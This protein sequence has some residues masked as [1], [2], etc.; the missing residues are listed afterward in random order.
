MITAELDDALASDDPEE[1]R[2]AVARLGDLDREAC[3]PRLLAA[4][5][6]DDWRVR[7][8]AIGAAVALAPAP[9]VLRA[10]VEAIGTGQ[11]VGLRNAA[12]EAL[13]GFGA[14]AVDALSV[15]ISQLDADGR[16]LAVEALGRSRQVEALAVLRGLLEDPD[17][18]V[19]ATAVEAVAQIGASSL[20][21]AVPLLE[22]CL[23]SGDR[24]LELAALDG[25]NQLGVILPWHS[26]ADLL[27][28]PV[29]EPAALVAA[30]R[31][32]HPAAATRIVRCLSRASGRRWRSALVA[33]AEYVQLSER[34]LSAARA[35][36]GDVPL[37]A[38]EELLQAARRAGDDPDERRAALVACGALG[39]EEAASAAIE[40]LSDDLVAAEGERA[41]GLLGPQAIK[42]LLGVARTGQPAARARCIDLLGQLGDQLPS[43]AALAIAAALES[44]SQDVVRAALAALAAIGDES[45]LARV[46]RC[47]D[48]DGPATL[49]KAAM[50][51]LA[52]LARRHPFAAR[53]L[54]ARAGPDSADALAAATV[55]GA[56]ESPVL[57]GV[58]QDVSFLSAALS[59]ENA[60][61]R[62]AAVDGLA[63][64]GSAL[65]VEAV[66]FALTDE[67][68]EVALAAV[69]ALG[70][71]RNQDGSIAGI[72]HLLELVEHSEDEALVAAAV[73]AL[74]DTGDVRALSALR[75]LVKS[76]AAMAGV[77]AVEALGRLPGPQA[78]DALIDALGHS[79][80]EVVKSA[81]R[82]LA[83][84]GEP[85][86]LAHLGA[87]LDHEAW[88]VRRLSAD[89]LGQSGR[90]TA[91]GMLRAKLGTE[92][93]PLVREAIQRALSEIEMAIGTVR[94]TAPPPR[95]G[96]WPPRS[97]S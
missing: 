31:S 82:V 56:L 43:D 69:R 11:G 35:A 13:S 81:L 8:E 64:I 79:D 96:T 88:D 18:N 37:S 25:L 49:R 10:L 38:R 42:V 46:A 32:G 92:D 39:G 41:L 78:I 29:L 73:Q 16:K 67:E 47:M 24:L 26:I 45:A 95:H 4:L 36:L 93:E 44:D 84:A 75:P 70:R 3:V 55:L 87:C 52:A 97:R 77:A 86:V 2:R 65:G 14:A 89:L 5:G 74:G 51:A 63:A 68:R 17:P 61:L 28:D 9:E 71:L 57:D 59:S 66:A 85:R 27:D 72:S 20:E 58:E 50:T 91:A 19:R 33:L 6:D 34:T 76:G 94:V 21:A 80:S 7:K 1:R 22:R 90:D 60:V 15:S 40:A 62:R 12:V 53:A 83:G 23:G 48:V 30:G 54:V